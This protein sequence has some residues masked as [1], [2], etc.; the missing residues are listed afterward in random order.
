[1]Q[2]KGLVWH[3]ICQFWVVVPSLIEQFICSG[4]ICMTTDATIQDGAQH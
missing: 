1:M 3:D 2:D 4:V